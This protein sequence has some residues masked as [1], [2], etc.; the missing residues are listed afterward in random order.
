MEPEAGPVG[1]AVACRCE[2][3]QMRSAA[4]WPQV[5][6]RLRAVAELPPGYNASGYSIGPMPDPSERSAVMLLTY[7]C[8]SQAVR[9]VCRPSAAACVPLAVAVRRDERDGG[10]R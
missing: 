5:S 8:W 2:C 1:V 4:R 9:M 3:E 10:S 6:G 7:S